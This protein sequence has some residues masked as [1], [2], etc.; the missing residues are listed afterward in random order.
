[1]SESRRPEFPEKLFRT[2]SDLSFL[3]TWDERA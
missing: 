2:L 3:V 1:M